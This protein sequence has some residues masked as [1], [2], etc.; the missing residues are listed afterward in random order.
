M[1]CFPM[2][3]C[4]SSGFP[5]PVPGRCYSPGVSALPTKLRCLTSQGSLRVGSV[6]K[7]PLFLISTSILTILPVHFHELMTELLLP[8]SRSTQ[9]TS[10]NPF[11]SIM[12]PQFGAF[13][14]PLGC[15]V[16]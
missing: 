6:T 13:S 9:N 11:E 8:T 12:L 5:V 10:E 2:L 7:I 1:A 3:L 15:E 4:I 14:F 16:V